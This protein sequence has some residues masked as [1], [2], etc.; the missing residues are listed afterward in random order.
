MQLM[1]SAFEIL[2]CFLVLYGLPFKIIQYHNLAILNQ[3][4]RRVRLLFS[5]HAT[6]GVLKKF[7]CKL[8][9]FLMLHLQEL[10]VVF[11]VS[12]KFFTN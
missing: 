7:T 2:I 6:N 8:A 12:T 3:I 11:R 10:N 4:I 1:I 9:K 5:S